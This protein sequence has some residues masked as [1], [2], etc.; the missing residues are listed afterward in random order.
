VSQLLHRR[1]VA[2][3]GNIADLE[4]QLQ[5]EAHRQGIE[6]APQVAWL[7]DGARGLWGLFERYFATLAVGI[8][9]FYHATQHPS[10]AAQAY[11]DTVPTRTSKEWFTR[12]RHQLRHGYVHRMIREFSALNDVLQAIDEPIEQ[13][14]T[15][16]AY[17]HR[18]GYDEI[19]A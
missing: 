19:A 11:G 16:G 18:H 9:D 15:D 3:R 5:L 6:S 17:D 8:L 14:S 13:V 4:G 7:S 12:L 1:L 10:E 2:V